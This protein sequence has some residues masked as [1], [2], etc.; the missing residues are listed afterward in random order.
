MRV[1]LYLLIAAVFFSCSKPLRTP[2]LTYASELYSIQNVELFHL[3]TSYTFFDRAIKDPKSQIWAFRSDSVPAGI[4]QLR[5]DKQVIPLIL[6]GSMPVAIS[7]TE[8]KLTITGNIPTQ[9]L[10]KAQQ[11]A[12]E[13]EDKV[14][15]LGQSFPDSLETSAFIHYKDSVF[16]LI[17][18]Q[19]LQTQ[20]QITHMINRNKD[21]L[22]PLLLVQLK[23]GNH[24]LFNYNTDANMYFTVDDYLQSY[25]AS[26]TPV[27]E[28]NQKVDSLRSW[29]YYTSVTL[30]GKTLPDISIPNAWNN[31]IPLS[32]FRGN[33]MLYLI[34]NSES[35]VSRNITKQL[36]K[37]SKTYRY[38]GV[39]LCLIATDSDKDK[40][41]DAI[42][43][44]QL[45][46]W[47]LCDLKGKNSPILAG[48]GITKIPTFILVNKEGTI[49]ER[50][51]D[52][53]NIT[54]ALNQLIQK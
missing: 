54:K 7:N 33:N 47:H 32:R 30:P 51:S 9:Q 48:L 14:N 27:I 11:V 44:D 19:K 6:E 1:S 20:K 10:W 25:N 42:K 31:P 52:Q 8:N 28:F 18:A 49:L 36:M 39:G 37:W 29:I 15:S 3:D 16:A 24:H 43:E 35:E 50:S 13:L 38:K 46:V 12:L 2:Y 4:Y 26:Y 34:W 40:W 41:Q 22:L 5:I 17:E 53:S 23:A 45:P 21:N